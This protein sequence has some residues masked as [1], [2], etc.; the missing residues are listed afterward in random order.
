ALASVVGPTGVDPWFLRDDFV[1]VMLR[2]VRDDKWFHEHGIGDSDPTLRERV[3]MLMQANWLR[4]RMFTS[5]A[6][7]ADDLEQAPVRQAIHDGAQAADLVDA[8]TGSKLAISFQ[9]ALEEAPFAYAGARPVDSFGGAIARIGRAP[10]P[11]Q[12]RTAN[13]PAA[14]RL[15]AETDSVSNQPA[16]LMQL[17]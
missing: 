5:A 11:L 17:A 8:A 10:R 13:A 4:Q 16:T 6:F 9:N 1:R 7:L 12:E 15:S 14:G 2:H 3:L